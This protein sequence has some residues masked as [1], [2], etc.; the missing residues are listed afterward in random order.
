[1]IFSDDD[2]VAALLAATSA[3]EM[4]DLLGDVNE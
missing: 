3:Q 4:F 2:S 1:M